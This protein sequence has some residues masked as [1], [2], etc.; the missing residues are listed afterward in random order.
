M[1]KTIIAFYD[2]LLY[3]IVCSLSIMVSLYIL[4]SRNCFSD[5]DSMIKNWYLVLSFAFCIDIPVGVVPMLRYFKIINNES[6]YFHYFPFTT[7]WTKAANNIDIRWNQEVF[8]S[9]I[10]SVEVLKLSKATNDNV[11]YDHWRNK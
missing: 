10:E 9:E 8:V 2:V 7:N 6:V 3:S 4:F 11:F 1:K 5:F